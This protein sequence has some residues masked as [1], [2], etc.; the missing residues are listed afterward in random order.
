MRPRYRVAT[1]VRLYVAFSLYTLSAGNPE[2]TAQAIVHGRWRGRTIEYVDGR[3]NII[4][5]KGLTKT[6]L[7]PTI[8][9]LP[10]RIEKDCTRQGWASLAVTD[11]TNIFRIIDLLELDPHIKS[12]EPDF[13]VTAA[14]VPNDQFFGLQ[15]GL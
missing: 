3:I 7:I 12:A 4:L 9:S 13:L 6:D 2:A 1:A 10:V 14:T 5:K 15:W 11:G 8:S